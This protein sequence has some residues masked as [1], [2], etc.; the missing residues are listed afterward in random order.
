MQAEEAVAVLVLVEQQLL[1]EAQAEE[2]ATVM[3]Q[4]LI[5]EVVE[6]VQ[7]QVVQVV[8]LTVL[9]VVQEL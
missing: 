1:G 8:L 7:V 5:L 9:M 2:A 3:L 4:H 6:E